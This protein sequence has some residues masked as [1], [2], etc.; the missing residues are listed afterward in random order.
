MNMISAHTTLLALSKM[1]NGRWDAIFN[2]IQSKK[3]IP[4]DYD[5]SQNHRCVT[6][7]DPDYPTKLKQFFKPPFCIVLRR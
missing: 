1:E 4:E 3:Q 5:V 7:V 6:L 2:D